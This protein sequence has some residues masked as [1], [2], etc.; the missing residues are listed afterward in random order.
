MR[1][2]SKFLK[3]TNR[4]YP[5]GTEHLLRKFLP[6]EH[7]MDLHGNFYVEIGKGSKTMFTCHL[8][9]AC[10]DIRKVKHTF[11][12]TLIKTDGRSILGADDKAGM[13]ILLYMIEKNVPGLY[14]FFIG[15][16][17]G[18]VGSSKLAQEFPDRLKSINRVISFDR[19]D[20]NSVIT[21]QSSTRCCSNDFAN[22][23]SRQLNINDSTFKYTPDDSGIYTDSAEF[24]EIIPECTN[25]SVGYKN[26]HTSIE[27]QD[28]KHLNKLCKAS[29]LVDWEN[30]PTKRDPKVIEHISWNSSV[31]N[32]YMTYDDF[33]DDFDDRFNSYVGTAYEEEIEARYSSRFSINN[34]ANV[35][36]DGNGTKKLYI[37]NE[38]INYE[39]LIIRDFLIELTDM[40]YTKIIWDGSS[41]WAH[42]SDKSDIIYI[43]EREELIQYIDELSE[44]PE[45]HLSINPYDNRYATM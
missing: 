21:H 45:E 27:S 41:C 33:D 32:R 31:K 38:R 44:I 11:N 26:E 9:T 10:K 14:Y 23:L 1:I 2:K 8:D 29:V 39:S 20:Y 17:V 25:I 42:G 35:N 7:I 16:E 5:H 4:T 34:Y 13:V 6:K 15:E 28:I 30:L 40:H 18:C 37:S 24:T 12:G 3:L 22:E 36:Y 19:R 43:G